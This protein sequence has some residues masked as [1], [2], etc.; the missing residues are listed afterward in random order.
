MSRKAFQAA[1][2]AFKE[3]NYYSAR[4]LLQEII[5]KD[6][7]GDYA[8]DAQYYLALTYYYEE[9]YNSALFEFKVFLRDYTMSEFSS[10]AEYWIGECHYYLKDYRSALQSHYDFVKKYPED[11][12][13]AYAYYTI[14]YIYNILKRYDDAVAEF[15]KAL[16]MYPASN[17]APKMALQLGISRYNNGD[18]GLARKQF[19]KMIQTMEDSTEVQ[20]AELWIGKT[21][22]AEKKYKEAEKQFLAVLDKYTGKDLA[23]EAMYQLALTR[24]KLN[25]LDDSLE[26]LNKILELYPKWSDTGSVYFRKGQILQMKGDFA[27]AALNYIQVI[28]NYSNIEFYAQ[29]L[30]L[31][32]DCY[33][34]TGQTGK[35]L[36][37]YDRILDGFGVE[38]DA[39]VAILQKKG[40]LLFLTG[41][42]RRSA[43]AF[44]RLYE[45][46]PASDLAP[47]AM[48]M[49]AQSHFKGQMYNVALEV[50]SQLEEKYPKSKWKQDAWFL[51]G[52]VYYAL[53]DY[54]KALQSYSKIIRFFPAHSRFFDSQMGVGWSYFELK[55]YA[56]AS[57]TFRRAEASAKTDR[58]KSEVHLAIASC[59][60]NL[61]A[62]DQAVNYYNSIIKKFPHEDA[63]QEAKFQIAWVYYR[64]NDF[65]KSLESF[66]NYLEMYPDGK[67]Q[68][69]AIYFK[70]WSLYN[71]NKYE[72]AL[73]EFMNVY[74]KAPAENIFR[75]KAL[76]DYAK[77]LYA[78]KKN[79]DAITYFKRFLREFPLSN[80]VE[81]TNYTLANALLEKGNPGEVE[82]LYKDFKKVKPDSL[83]LGEILRNL[84]TYYRKNK[85]YS[86]AD[87]IYK[88][89]I[90]DSEKIEQKIDVSF[91]RIKMYSESGDISEALSIASDLLT[92]N[93]E[94]YAPFRLKI[95]MQIVQL[96]IDGGN[97]SAAL[98]VIETQKKKSADDKI[99]L[100]SLGLQE[101]RVYLINKDYAKSAEIMKS[102]LPIKELTV[103]PRYYLA[104]GYYETQKYGEASEFFKQVVQKT[105]EEYYAA[106]A[107]YYLG[108]IQFAKQDYL[109]AAREYTK[110]IYLYSGNHDLFEKALFKAATC[111][112]QA[113]K[114]NE[115]K[116]YKDK[117]KESFPESKFLENL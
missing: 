25:A 13:A 58:Q 47:E 84:G 51:D 105:D 23:P 100:A 36:D 21:Y 56:R 80:S 117:L 43:M 12:H 33:Q 1:M 107:F 63:A 92:S 9:D 110:I 19:Q 8:D 85:N 93:A 41:D 42:F 61:R 20:E 22:Y 71:K 52:E 97:T 112:K 10:R 54:T 96:Y 27:E 50:L 15:E 31:L 57:D 78:M 18:F 103:A 48:Y 113:G 74:G 99:L 108:E 67:R 46:F 87:N 44:E 89:I 49:R 7:T 91:Q 72:E 35:A 5:H 111:F 68:I 114:N 76:L 75:E 4:L 3:R 95:I 38:S 45:K 115:Y 32:A 106:W 14:G 17:V 77:T 79:D 65:L 24:Y 28:D 2:N 83:Y 16:E 101:G 6:H 98:E 26:Y 69:E 104:L 70:G 34:K 82:K 11:K 62:F 94:E 39:E 109:M 64:Q 59:M 81:E 90:K 29:S 60:Y 30:E 37:I 53:T 102:L 73:A 86:K 55:Q 88:M 40:N 66:N 116:T